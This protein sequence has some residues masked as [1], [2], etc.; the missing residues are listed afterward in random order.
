MRAKGLVTAYV[1]VS[2]F[3]CTVP[4]Y[5]TMLA[6]LKLLPYRLSRLYPFSLLCPFVLIVFLCLF[7]LPACYRLLKAAHRDMHTLERVAQ[8]QDRRTRAE[9][10]LEV[11]EWTAVQWTE[12]ITGAAGGCMPIDIGRARRRPR[13]RSALA[14]HPSRRWRP[15]IL[16][17]GIRSEACRILQAN[18]W[19]AGRSKATSRSGLLVQAETR[20]VRHG[21]RSSWRM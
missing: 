13:L 10:L 16:S 20:S 6:H 7:P 21:P 12:C 3:P 18:V 14:L 1:Q 2:A 8:L 5:S 15:K 9:G 19:G 4:M 11:C 17:V